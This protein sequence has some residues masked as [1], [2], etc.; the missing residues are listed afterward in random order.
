MNMPSAHNPGVRYATV[1]GFK[2]NNREEHLDLFQSD[3]FTNMA[4]LLK[5]NNVLGGLV[6]GCGYQ[7][8]FSLAKH[9]FGPTAVYVGVRKNGKV[10]AYTYAR[11]HL[12]D[13]M[14]N[15]IYEV[16][17]DGTRPNKHGSNSGNKW[18]SIEGDFNTMQSTIMACALRCTRQ[19]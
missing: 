4:K 5:E 19:R 6:S 9:G 2:G 10:W 17:A 3:E 1:E 14:R 8:N 11:E 18:I 13:T 15:P 7:F 12:T 16:F